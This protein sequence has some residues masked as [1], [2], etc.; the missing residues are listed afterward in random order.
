MNV[1]VGS[2]SYMHTP[3][4]DSPHARTHHRLSGSLCSDALRAS[5]NPADRWVCL[6]TFP[7]KSGYV[8]E[9]RARQLKALK[10]PATSFDTR[11]WRVIYSTRFRSG[12]HS[13]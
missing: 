4:Q 2:C 11:L 6:A 5:I 7:L 8:G 10:T 13:P 3:I 12:P 9:T 1:S